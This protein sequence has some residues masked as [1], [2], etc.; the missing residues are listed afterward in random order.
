[1]I[2]SDENTWPTDVI[3]YLE[4]EEG[5]FRAWEEQSAGLSPARIVSGPE[6]DAALYGLRAALDACELRGYHCTR[7]TESEI[8]HIVANGMQLPSGSMLRKRIHALQGD[9]L[10]DATVAKRLV[11]KNQADEENRAGR[12]WFCFFPPYLAGESGIESLL[13][14]WGGEA[15]YNLHDRD[16]ETEPILA[17][18]GTPCLIEAD[19]PIS[20]MKGPSFLDMKVARQFL[21]RRGFRSSEPV[22]HE[23]RAIKA[24]PPQNIKRIIRYPERDFIKL[25]RC[26][27]WEKPLSNG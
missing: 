18:I 5:T 21:M 20:S 9:G 13:R 27:E 16:P 7:L 12:I 19:V 8:G 1:M 23:D 2:L 26:D 10:I 11:E 25:T 3:K 6:Y 22:E 17:R 24:I 14:Y 4:R 15:L